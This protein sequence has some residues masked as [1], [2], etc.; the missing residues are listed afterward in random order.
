VPKSIEADCS[1]SVDDK[2]M[3][4]LATVP[5]GSRVNF[6][7]GRCYGQDGTITLTDRNGLVIDGRGSEFRALTL[8]GSHRA[9]WR[10]VGGSDLTVRNM[11]VRGSNPDRLYQAGFEWQHGYSVEG[12]QGMTLSNVQAREVWGDGVYLDHGAYTPSC[13]DDASSARD[14]LITGAVLERIGR[15]GVAVVDAEY[16]TVQDSA[17]GSALT[18]V[19]LEPDDPCE[20]ARHITVARNSFGANQWGGIVNGGTGA[21][22]HVGDV[23]VIDNQQTAPANVCWAAPVQVWSSSSAYRDNYSFRGNQFIGHWEAFALSGVRNVDV[24]SNAVSFRASTSGGPCPGGTGV[25]LWESHIVHIT[26]NSFSGADNV[27]LADGLSTG[28]TSVGNTL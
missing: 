17:I 9:N 10:F 14:V 22:P 23:S 24:S 15:M 16:V 3:T 4:W 12:V 1:V 28:I 18:W 2:V 13:G 11:A 21:Y 7:A 25:Y 20:L 27:F 6:R 5:D 19:D 8:G 26:G